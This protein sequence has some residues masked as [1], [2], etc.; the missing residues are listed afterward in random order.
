MSGITL[1]ILGDAA[2][3]KRAFGQV[4]SAQRSANTALSAEDR[5]VNE[6]RRKGYDADAA[7][8]AKAEKEKTRAERREAAER[9][10]EA[11]AAEREKKKLAD[12]AA[13][14]AANAEKEKTR[15]AA[16]ESK[17]R[18]RLAAEETKAMEREAN[19]RVNSQV[20]AEARVTRE[21]ERYLKQRKRLR[22]QEARER[23]Q[24]GRGRRATGGAVGQAVVGAATQFA[25][26]AH[27][28]VQ[29]AR[30]ERASIDSSVSDAVYQSGGSRADAD[31]VTQ[32]VMEF[33][34]EHNMS[35]SEIASAMQAAQTEFSAL[36][37]KDTSLDQ[38]NRNISSFL[39]TALLARNTGNSV[40]EF[41]RLAGL[42]N[43]TRIDPAMQRQLMLYTAGAA[44]RGSIEAGAVTSSAMAS[45]RRRIGQAIAHARSTGA[46]PQQ[47]AA[48]EYRQAF[49]ELEVARSAGE[50]PI[51][52]GN[53]I[54]AMNV[55]L[56][57][58]VSQEN[59]YTNLAHMENRE[60]RGRLQST[61]FD[62]DAQGHHR[63]KAQYH[64]SL[65]LMQAFGAQ[66][67]DME[68]FMNITRGGGHGNPM[69]LLANQRRVLGE[70]LN[71]DVTGRRG[72]ERITDIMDHAALDEGD[73]SRG[74]EMFGRSEAAQLIR[75]HEESLS[76]ASGTGRWG[77]LSNQFERFTAEHPFLSLAT[78]LTF[79]QH[80]GKVGQW[81][82]SSI[83]G[84]V[85][86][87]I[88][89]RG[90]LG[91]MV[92]EL[93]G[94]AATPAAIVGGSVLTYTGDSLV[95]GDE[96]AEMLRRHRATGGASSRPSIVSGAAGP[97]AWS[98]AS[99]GAGFFGAV[100]SPLTDAI[101]GLPTG[102]RDAFASNPP[103]VRMNA[104]DVVHETTR[105]GTG[106]GA[107]P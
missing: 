24:Q 53:A 98:S 49:A 93:L 80:G 39:D 106:S 64:D 63:L 70:L 11:K 104:E 30:N 81:I 8:A 95:T 10:R 61:L 84:R 13:R 99:R 55:A 9:A 87:A 26:Q 19:E 56:G 1:T 101:K 45:I 82:G 17:L 34:R 46:N 29:S 52:A 2:G 31:A 96:E 3:V 71:P 69:S 15:A 50:T 42:F 5:A 22:D 94:A 58:N 37:D 97:D 86:G 36:G 41:G 76:S 38:R 100:L 57:S 12:R 43:D 40:T 60:L 79:L 25:T 73:V 32:R 77:E 16:R 62:T 44:Q 6:R 66:G 89:A 72:I 91:S 107:T 78:D 88:A 33:A 75:D 18:E 74:A 92:S 27:G 102:I 54:S 7:A 105:A 14:D 48:H 67:V 68:T 4:V 85:G 83:A 65:A 90:G 103:V 21:V 59:M 35:S 23:D 20:R 47:A 28:I 51:A